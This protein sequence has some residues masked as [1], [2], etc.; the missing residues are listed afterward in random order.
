MDNE[1]SIDSEMDRVIDELSPQWDKER[2][3]EIEKLG[4][5]EWTADV[6]MRLRQLAEMVKKGSLSNATDAELHSRLIQIL[7]LFP[8]PFGD[9]A[10]DRRAKYEAA[11][12][13]FKRAIAEQDQRDE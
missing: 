13:E 9:F 5:P 2:A 1:R 11:V 3:V 12:E 6:F 7:D 10:D 8:K 4:H